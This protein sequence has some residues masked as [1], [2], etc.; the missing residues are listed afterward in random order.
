MTP[1][2]RGVTAAPNRS[3]I[4]AKVLH[5]EQSADFPDKWFL[6]LE[7]LVSKAMQG[8]NF[9]RVGETVG[10]FTFNPPTEVTSGTVVSAHA[11]FLGDG[12][13]GQFQLTDI[14]IVNSD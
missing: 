6:G 3:E 10:A 11:E 9:A 2:F 4:E 13:G 5:V 7:I 8:P 14:R 1:D 12:R